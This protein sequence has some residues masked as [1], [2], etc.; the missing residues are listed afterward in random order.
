MLMLEHPPALLLPLWNAMANLT[1]WFDWG[2][3]EA[4]GTVGALW[5]AVV[6]SSRSARAERANRVAIL[7][8]L[9]SLLAPIT[10]LAPIY[11][12]ADDDRLE[13]D[14]IASLLMAREV[15]DWAAT[16]I[17]SITIADA[18]SVGATQYVSALPVALDT[19]R[20]LLPKNGKDSVRASTINEGTAYIREAVTFFEDQRELIQYGLLARAA[21]RALQQRARPRRRYHRP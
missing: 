19:L 6:Q 7:T 21:R 20:S 12:E 16:G 4:I 1:G 13:A 5:F 14:D 3:L 9:T 15:V 18:A 11:D 8:T 17:K 2:A 10:E